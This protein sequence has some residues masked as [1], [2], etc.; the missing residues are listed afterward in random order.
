[1]SAEQRPAAYR[2]WLRDGKIDVLPEPP[3]PEDREFALDTYR[4]LVAKAREL[5]ERLR[6]TNSAGRVAN[7]I[8]RLLTALGTRFEDLRP[9]VLLS[10]SRDIDADRVAFAGELLPDTIAMMD[11]TAQTLRDLLAS[12]PEVRLIEAEVLALDLDR[13]ADVIPAIREQMA[14]ITAAAEKSGAVTLEALG[15]LTQN[16]AAIED[17]IN[18]VAQR[19]LV[20]DKLL[21]IRNF[22]SAILDGIASYG[23]KAGTGLAELAEK[24]WDEI[25]N[26]LPKSI[27]A[28]AALV[29]PI[30]LVGLAVWLSD[31][32]TGVAVSVAAFRPMAKILK[33]LARGKKPAKAKKRR[34]GV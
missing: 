17:A 5:Q 19:G 9:G 1:M 21:V 12:F 2:F 13:S 22:V 28:T 10:R 11:G 23:A 29:P 8:E 27:G 24:S 33:N 34:Q 18:L 15:A 14:A 31:P 30:A 32:M 3:D 7:T 20:A 4:E 16:D 25:N 26:Q 6:G